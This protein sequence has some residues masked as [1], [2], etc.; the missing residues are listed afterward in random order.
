MFLDELTKDT[1]NTNIIVKKLD[2][3]SLES[4]REFAQQINREEKK[5]DVLIHNAGTAETFR[6][7]VTE[8]GLEMTMATNHFGPF[9]LTHLLIGDLL[10]I[11]RNSNYSRMI[12]YC[13]L[14][15]KIETK[16][17][18]GGGFWIVSI[19]FIEFEQRESHNNFASLSLLR[20]EIR[21]YS[22]YP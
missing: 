7:K 11:P 21:E 20:F 5:L 19:G 12:S 17:Y 13:R 1:N 14:I 6:K 18:S 2:L 10:R 16:S 3:S 8:D 15:E 9:L 4:I 22:F